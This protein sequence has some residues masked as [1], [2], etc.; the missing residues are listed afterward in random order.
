[1]PKTTSLRDA[2]DVYRRV[3]K[4]APFRFFNGNTMAAVAKM[5]V[6][7][8]FQAMPPMPAQMARSTLAHYV[9]GAIKASELE[10]VLGHVGRLW[11]ET[12]Q[13]SP[14]SPPAAS[15]A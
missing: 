6:G 14:A 5:M 7:E 1:M 9:V 15:R 12:E 11:R 2:L 3:H 8:V 4:L 10:E 13:G